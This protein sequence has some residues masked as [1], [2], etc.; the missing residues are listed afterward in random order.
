MFS[1]LYR[2]S[3]ASFSLALTL[4]AS[5]LAF[6]TPLFAENIDL[7]ILNIGPNPKGFAIIGKG[8]FD[9]LGR[10]VSGA[11]DVNGDG[12][13][14]IIIGAY[15]AYGP[16]N[17]RDFA[18]ESYVLFGKPT[19]FGNIELTTLDQGATA[20]GFAILGASPS[21]QSG[22]SVS[23][24]GDV[25][26]DGF[27]DLLIGSKS[28]D[29]PNDSRDSAGETYVLFGKASGFSNIDL[30]SFDGGSTID[31]FAILGADADDTSGIS[32]SG[33]GDLNGDGFADILIGSYRFTTWYNPPVYSSDS[34]VLFGKASGFTNIDLATL[35]E[36][37]SADGFAIIGTNNFDF[38]GRSVSGAGDINGDGF[39]DIIIGA[40]MAD[41]QGNTRNAAGVSY[42]LL[43]KESGFNP[44]ELTILK[45]GATTDGFAIQ[46]ANAS[47]QSGRC[48][49]GAGDVNG[50]GFA[51]VLIGAYFADGPGDARNFAG[52]SYL[53]FGKNSGFNN[54]DLATFDA[55]ATADGFAILG[56][57]NYDSSGYSVSGAG[58]VNG[59]GFADILIGASTADGGSD[60]RRSAGQ[61]YVLYGKATDFS[62]FDLATLV[63]ESLPDGFVLHGAHRYDLSG[64]SVSGSGDV[65]GDG[66]ADILIGARDADGPTNSRFHAGIAYGLF[67][68]GTAT[69]ATYKS[70]AK[71]GN[72]PYIA[73]GITGDGSNDS[74]PDSRAW[75]DFADG[76]NV[77]LQTVTLT[78]NDSSIADLTDTANVM[79][80]VS[81]DRT[82]WTSAEVTFKYTN[83]ELLGLSESSLKLFTAPETSGPWT[84]VSGS[85]CIAE[86]NQI[87]GTVSGFGFFAIQ[88]TPNLPADL[89][90]LQ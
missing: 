77:S 65:N 78:R 47:D 52:D 50:D 66:F 76:D 4:L 26:G 18:G 75:I 55:G 31:G 20:D 59:D 56:A 69:S 58:D 86:R 22:R 83:T 41:G 43:G 29:G 21:D 23:G 80:E 34:Y 15:N 17:T 39:A 11:G 57:S 33:V 82:G 70:F 63:E 35:K 37:T 53:I 36:E 13:A 46:G 3:S 90:M 88:G 1:T 19:G 32:V 28:A 72:A 71:I 68:K 14:D 49:S 24:A 16:E 7:A 8:S 25:N 5:G 45:E 6:S 54:I 30:V 81:S 42:V 2:R 67:G 44:I 62:N 89:W 60:E 40:S 64:I 12:F 61:T 9:S 38:S 74:T 27:A 84:E 51:D 10:S 73:I 85:T 87:K 79:W 48:V